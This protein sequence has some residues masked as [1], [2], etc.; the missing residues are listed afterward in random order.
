MTRIELLLHKQIKKVIIIIIIIIINE[1]HSR[2]TT[3]GRKRVKCKICEPGEK[4]T[5]LSQQIKDLSKWL[6]VTTQIKG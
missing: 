2:R 6:H 5:C 4:L 3:E 1:L